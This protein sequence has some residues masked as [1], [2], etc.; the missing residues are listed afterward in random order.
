MNSS[1]TVHIFQGQGV[2]LF[3]GE[4]TDDP[5]AAER[6]RSLAQLHRHSADLLALPTQNNSMDRSDLP[7]RR[8]SRPAEIATHRLE[9]TEFRCSCSWCFPNPKDEWPEC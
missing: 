5:A 6:S 8:A 1:I 9:W 2:V 3:V 7:L 4:E